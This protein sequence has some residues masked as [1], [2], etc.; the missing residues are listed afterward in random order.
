LAA[1]GIGDDG[2]RCRRRRVLVVVFL[3]LEVVLRILAKHAAPGVR[4]EV[5]RL[6]T[7]GNSCEPVI[8]HNME[9]GRDGTTV[10]IQNKGNTGSKLG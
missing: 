4:G 9:L 6:R 2:I 7:G 5:R 1:K 10:R 8:K 3:Q